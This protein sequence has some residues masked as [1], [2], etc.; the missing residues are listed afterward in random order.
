MKGDVKILTWPALDPSFIPG[1]TDIRFRQQWEK[2]ITAICTLTQGNEFKCF[3]ELQKEFEL[4]NKDFY[5]H[6]QMRDYYK[7]DQEYLRR[8][9]HL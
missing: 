8:K 7:R 4:E 2:G 1:I 6:L 5:M 9:M 3:R